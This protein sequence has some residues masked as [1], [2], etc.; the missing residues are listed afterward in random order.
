MTNHT[1]T[2]PSYHNSVIPLKS[3]KHTVSSN[4]KPNT[5]IE[6]EENPLLSTEQLDLIIIPMSQKLGLRIPD[7]YMAV[8]WNPGGQAIILKRNSNIGYARES[9]YMENTLTNEKM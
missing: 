1:V 3:I 5:L 9:D 7:E 4:M 8:L 2:I 6:I